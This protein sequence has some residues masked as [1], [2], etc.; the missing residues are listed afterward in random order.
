MELPASSVSAAQLAGCI[1]VKPRTSLSNSTKPAVGSGT[2]VGG[3]AVG[4]AVGAVVAGT[5]VGSSSPPPHATKNKRVKRANTFQ[6]LL[7]MMFSLFELSAISSQL[8][9]S[10]F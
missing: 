5:A 7:D 3:T 6:I 4:A 10:H 9:V 8:R 1:M 2:A